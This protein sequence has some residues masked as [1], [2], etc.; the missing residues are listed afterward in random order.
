MS[1]QPSSTPPLARCAPSS[2]SD[3]YST[4]SSPYSVKVKITSGDE[5]SDWVEGT[6]QITYTEGLKNTSGGVALAGEKAIFDNVLVGYDTNEDNDLDPE[7]EGLV[8]NETFA[9]T[10]I[11]P[12]YDH[13]GN[14]TFDGT[15]KHTYDA[16]P[17]TTRLMSHEVGRAGQPETSRSGP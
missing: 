4:A 10:T 3:T 5:A 15:Y 6:L 1:T 12:T 2:A 9:G 16:W 8:V 7:N 14:L 13:N 17:L 11:T